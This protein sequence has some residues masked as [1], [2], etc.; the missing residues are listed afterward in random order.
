MQ[1]EHGRLHSRIIIEKESIL[2]EGAA[3]AYFADTLATPD[4]PNQSTLPAFIT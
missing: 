4:L 1:H 3:F 2:Y